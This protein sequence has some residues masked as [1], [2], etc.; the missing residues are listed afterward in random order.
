[1]SAT[2]EVGISTQR[3]FKDSSFDYANLCKLMHALA[4]NT[5][6]KLNPF[7]CSELPYRMVYYKVRSQFYCSLMHLKSAHRLP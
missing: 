5:E 7:V 6:P 3:L 1:M 4:N 2:N